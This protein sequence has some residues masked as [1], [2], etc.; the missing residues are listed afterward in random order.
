[1]INEN[2]Q[3]GPQLRRGRAALFRGCL[4]T[5]PNQSPNNASA[6]L[7][8]SRDARSRPYLQL[9]RR[10]PD[11]PEERSPALRAL[12]QRFILACQP[13]VLAAPAVRS[14]DWPLHNHASEREP[15]PEDFDCI[16]G[17]FGIEAA[18]LPAFRKSCCSPENR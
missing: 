10:A 13:A 12:I 3:Q 17:E 14:C 8:G 4:N 15:G 5:N 11:S 18:L 2:V 1:M 6:P 16:E 9:P 7:R